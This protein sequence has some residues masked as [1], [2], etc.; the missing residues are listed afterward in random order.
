M[1]VTGKRVIK[2][3]QLC[4]GT[5]HRE[6]GWRAFVDTEGPD[7]CKRFVYDFGPQ[8]R[9]WQSPLFDT[10]AEAKAWLPNGVA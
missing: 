10:E 6:K 2:N 3:R 5:P 8:R 1:T 9:T 7:R 4:N